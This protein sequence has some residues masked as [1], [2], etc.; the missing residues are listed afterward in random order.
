M[1]KLYFKQA[2]AQLRQQPIISLVSILGTALAIFLIM[3]VVMIQQV[4]VAPFSPETDECKDSQGMFQVAYNSRS[5]NHLL[6]CCHNYSGFHAGYTCH[7]Y[8]YATDG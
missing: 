7:Q 2:L 5:S 4:K 8:R 1:I 3:L 6:C